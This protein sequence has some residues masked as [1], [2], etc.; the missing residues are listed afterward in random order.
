[1]QLIAWQTSILLQAW[2]VNVT[3]DK[4]LETDK[5]SGKPKTTK[6]D[7]LEMAA[8]AREKGLIKDATE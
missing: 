6:A 8:K 7:V 2:G 1:M 5:T 4:L 3:P